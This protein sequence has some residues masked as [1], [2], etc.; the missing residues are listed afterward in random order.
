MFRLLGLL[1]PYAFSFNVLLTLCQGEYSAVEAG[2]ETL[3]DANLVTAGREPN[4]F[5]V[6]DLMRAFARERLLEEESEE[7]VRDLTRLLIAFYLVFSREADKVLFDSSQASLFTSPI[8]ATDWLEAE[9]AALVHI[10]GL[11]YNEK[12]YAHALGCAWNIERFLERRL[13]GSSWKRISNLSLKAA[14][15]YGERKSLLHAL[16]SA[17]RCAI[18]FPSSD[19]SI[20]ALLDEARDLASELG[21]LSHKAQV[22]YELGRA[23]AR[24]GARNRSD[25]EQLFRNAAEMARKSKSH[26]VEGNALSELGDI[27]ARNGALEEAEEVFRRARFL[28]HARRDRHCTGNAWKDI[29]RIRQKVGDF[30]GAAHF[31]RLALQCYQYVHDVHCAGMSLLDLAEAYGGMGDEAKEREVCREAVTFFTSLK[32]DDCLSEALGHLAQLDVAA[33]DYNSAI[34]RHS[35]VAALLESGSRR[36]Y[37]RQLKILAETVQLARGEE[38]AEAYWARAITA[39]QGVPA[40]EQEVQRRGAPAA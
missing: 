18:K 39:S 38:E 9:H 15:D 21:S 5:H 22:T 12:L 28:Y 35:Q 17:V 34:D 16:I 23:A 33:G 32:D 26:H 36:R 6:H 27:L 11:A 2:L 1:P 10:I 24:S 25:A 8:Q 3:S 4:R 14:R 20:I 30:A 37:V 40:L 7:E 19:L 31:Y 29:G 13:H